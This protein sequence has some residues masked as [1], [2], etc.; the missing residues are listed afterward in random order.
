MIVTSSYHFIINSL[1]LNIFL[2]SVAYHDDTLIQLFILLF[3]P[4]KKISHC[5]CN[6]HEEQY[7]VILILY[8]QMSSS[9]S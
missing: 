5:R 9:V 1:Y 4:S 6:K 3:K 7:G 2:Q 8:E